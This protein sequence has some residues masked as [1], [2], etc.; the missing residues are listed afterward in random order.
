MAIWQADSFA[1]IFR[2]ANAAILSCSQWPCYSRSDHSS[3]TSGHNYTRSGAG[4]YNFNS[5]A[6]T[7]ASQYQQYFEAGARECN[8][9]GIRYPERDTL[10]RN[11]PTHLL[12]FALS[13]NL[14]LYDHL[15]D[16]LYD[17]HYDYLYHYLYNYL[18]HYLYDHI[19]E[20]PYEY[21]YDYLH[22]HPHDINLSKPL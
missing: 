18:Y 15:Y 13:F 8:P 20:Y 14:H 1:S 6:A 19:Y 11:R 3:T 22:D 10:R 7:A 17:Y 5:T 9:P 2:Y 12:L 4:Y 21:L 16:Y